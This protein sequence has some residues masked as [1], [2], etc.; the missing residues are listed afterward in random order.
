MARAGFPIGK[1]QLLDSVQHI[2]IELKRNNP[3][4]NNR[5]GKSW[6]GSFLKRNE[7]I[8]LRTPQNLTASRA[9][10][11]K[12]QLNIWFSEVY[13]YLKIEKYDHILEYPSRVFNADEA[14]FF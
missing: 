2:M 11:T 6:Y 5:P 14:A 7:N 3:F 13:K 4:K 9:S 10:V 1:T 12:S 8:S